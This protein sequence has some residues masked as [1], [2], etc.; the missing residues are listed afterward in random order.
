MPFRSYLLNSTANPAHFHSG[1]VFLRILLRTHK[2]QCPH[3]FGPNYFWYRWCVLLYLFL[4]FSDCGKQERERVGSSGVGLSTGAEA[5]ILKVTFI[6]KQMQFLTESAS[7]D[8]IEFMYTKANWLKI[9]FSEKV[10]NN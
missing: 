4:S 7:K 5:S 1:Y 8:K 6:L 9:W 10:C 3:I 2:P